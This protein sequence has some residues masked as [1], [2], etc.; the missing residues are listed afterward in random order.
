MALFVAFSA[1]YFLV[2]Y[3]RAGTA[4]LRF[5]LSWREPPTIYGFGLRGI[6][7]PFWFLLSSVLWRLRQDTLLN[8]N[9]NGRPDAP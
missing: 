9:Q 1:P 7:R 2:V 8:K 3:A 4:P 5:F 6:G